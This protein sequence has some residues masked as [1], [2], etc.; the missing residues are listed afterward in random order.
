MC[1]FHPKGRKGGDSSRGQRLRSVPPGVGLSANCTKTL[2]R[3]KKRGQK[4]GGLF[5]GVF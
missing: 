4:G 2:G 1:P 3:R 5:P